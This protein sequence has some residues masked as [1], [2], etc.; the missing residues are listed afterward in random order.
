MDERRVAQWRCVR[1]F[2][3]AVGTAMRMRADDMVAETNFLHVIGHADSLSQLLGVDASPEA[4]V[5]QEQ[6]LQRPVYNSAVVHRPNSEQRYISGPLVGWLLVALQDVRMLLA[7]HYGVTQLR[8]SQLF[9]VVFDPE[10]PSLGD[11]RLYMTS[12]YQQAIAAADQPPQPADSNML[13]V[14]A[15]RIELVANAV[16][17]VLRRAVPALSPADLPLP[18]QRNPQRHDAQ[19]RA[20]RWLVLQQFL[21]ALGTG[22]RM[23][24]ADMISKSDFLGAM[25]VADLGILLNVA[26][27]AAAR[28]AQYDDDDDAGDDDDDDQ[29]VAGTDQSEK[30]FISG[31][32][33][34]WLLVALQVVASLRAP[35]RRYNMQQL[36]TIL[37]DPDFPYIGNLRAYMMARYQQYASAAEQPM[38]R[39]DNLM[40][41]V[42]VYHMEVVVHNVLAWP[43]QQQRVPGS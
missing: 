20:S 41:E 13:A 31:L 16:C 8:Q 39:S 21:A 4:R 11:L 26:P 25:A 3:A 33:V 24:P 34:G 38:P 35:P 2:L 40:L 28:R 30:A 42:A 29:D 14:A 27:A 36:Y 7:T 22:L 10:F 43:G 32:L 19:L 17:A 6:R 9:D 5:Q 15:Y 23:R 1:Q 12:R 37:F 18:Q